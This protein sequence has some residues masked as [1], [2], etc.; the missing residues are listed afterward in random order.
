MSP[1]FSDPKSTLSKYT[2]KSRDLT[3]FLSSQSPIG[4][5]GL[6]NKY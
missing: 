3:F 5:G 2:P 1:Y 6:A 4:Q